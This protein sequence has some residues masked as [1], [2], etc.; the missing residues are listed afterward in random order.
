MSSFSILFPSFPAGIGAL[1]VC[2][3]WQISL[4]WGPLPQQDPQSRPR[5]APVTWQCS[6]QG[7]SQHWDGKMARPACGRRHLEMKK[8]ELKTSKKRLCRFKDPLLQPSI[9][10]GCVAFKCG[11]W[12]FGPVWGCKW[13]CTMQFSCKLQQPFPHL[14]QLEFMSESTNTYGPAFGQTIRIRWQHGDRIYTVT[15]LEGTPLSSIV[16][17][18]ELW[19]TCLTVSLTTKKPCGWAGHQLS[20]S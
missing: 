15:P 3:T 7:A 6:G 2:R 9:D 19:E 5:V 8:W 11:I 16:H 12:F 1:V 20:R 4:F 18:F 14:S 17:N 10:S 13:S